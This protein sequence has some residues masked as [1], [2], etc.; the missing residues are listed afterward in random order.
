MKT[1]EIRKSTESLRETFVERVV[2]RHTTSRLVLD[3]FGKV[4]RGLFVPENGKTLAYQDK[5]VWLKDGSSL[6]APGLVATMTDQLDLHGTEKVLEVGTGSGY[7]GAILSHCAKEVHSIEY[8]PQLAYAAQLNLKKLGRDNVKVYRG[9]GFYGLPEIAPFDA[10][11]VTG[12][13]RDVPSLLMDQLKIGGRM[14]VPIG[15]HPQ[16]NLDLF[17]FQKVSDE[18]SW[19]KTIEHV[20]FYPVISDAPGGWH[21]KEL[22]GLK[23]Q[24]EQFIQWFARDQGLDPEVVYERLALDFGL[25]PDDK[26]AIHRIIDSK[27]EAS[28]HNSG[29]FDGFPKNPT[30]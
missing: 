14:V 5:T 1:V 20:N 27:L 24:A 7:S 18:K 16:L 9:D 23:I 6:S 4:D 30:L 25:K 12:A 2:W 3:A 15:S 26:P 10:V 11:I 8:D 29:S 22:D 13:A 17:V 28:D 21:E 19:S